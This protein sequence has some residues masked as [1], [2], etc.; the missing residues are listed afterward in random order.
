MAGGNLADKLV[1]NDVR[2]SEPQAAEALQRVV[3]GLAYMHARGI[4]H[5][6]LKTDNLLLA[7]DGSLKIGDFGYAA[8]VGSDN[9]AMLGTPYWMPPEVVLKRAYDEVRA[10]VRA[11]VLAMVCLSVDV[12]CARGVQRVDVWSLGICAIEMI[13]GEPPYMCD[14]PIKAMF[15]ICSQEPAT[16]ASAAQHSAA[17]ND[18]VALCLVKVRRRCVRAALRC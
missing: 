7:R 8:E 3:D 6:D 14:N 2:L 18:F 1:L 17:L 9:T 11:C 13:D 5:R 4:Y 16:L 12:W 15:H 10:R